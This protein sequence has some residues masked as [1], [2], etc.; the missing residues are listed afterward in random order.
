MLLIVLQNKERS[1]LNKKVCCIS[2][3]RDIPPESE[4]RIRKELFEKIIDAI[5]NGY[6]VFI[7]GFARGTDIMAAEIIIDFKKRFGN[8]ADIKLDAYLPYDKM[9]NNKKI[10]ELLKEC[11]YITSCSPYYHRGCFLVRDKIMAD[12]ADMLIAVTDEEETGGTGYTIR[13]AEKNKIPIERILL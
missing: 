2:G 5:N 11:D 10:K 12:N 4:E 3:K 1:A 7:C 8:A 9:Q 13:C 6:N